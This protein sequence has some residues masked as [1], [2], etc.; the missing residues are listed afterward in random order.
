MAADI[1]ARFA[2]ETAKHQLTVLHDDGLYKHLKFKQPGDSAYWFDLITVPGSLIFRGDGESFVFARERDMFGFFRSNPDRKTM[3]ISP[4]YWA[5]KL[6]SDRDSVRVYS[7]EVFDRYVAEILKD[8]EEQWPG[9]TDAWVLETDDAFD[10]N[11]DH[12]QS[13]RDALDSFSYSP[14]GDDETAFRFTDTWE[15]SFRDFDW[16]YLWGCHAIVWGI[17]RYDAAT[18]ARS[19]T[20]PQQR[21]LMGTFARNIRRCRSGRKGYGWYQDGDWKG[22]TDGPAERIIALRLAHVQGTGGTGSLLLP[23]ALGEAVRDVL[24]GAA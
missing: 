4:D 14:K 23:T 21:A 10:Y 5:E 22:R 9:V 24:I 15:A 11:L 20:V 12:E 7:R 19:L 16:W 8:A 1:A 13:A 3:R 6:T 2:R 18:I 17:A